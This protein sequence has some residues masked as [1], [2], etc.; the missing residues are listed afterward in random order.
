MLTPQERRIASVAALESAAIERYAEGDLA[1]S[2]SWMLPRAVEALGATAGVIHVWPTGTPARLHQSGLPP[3]AAKAFETLRPTL[4]AVPTEAKE[5]SVLE[6]DVWPKELRA[7]LQAA[8]MG[9]VLLLPLSLPETKLTKTQSALLLIFHDEPP[10]KLLELGERVARVFR[11]LSVHSLIEVAKGASAQVEAV[12]SAAVDAVIV[13]DQTGRIEI[14]NSSTERIFGRTS[15]EMI[16]QNVSTLMPEPY[17][18]DHDSYLDNYLRTGRAKIIG[19]GREARGLR[20]DGT[21]FPIDLAV[22]EIAPFDGRR[23]F[24]G[25]VR[26][27]STRKATERQLEEARERLAH[28]ARISTMGEL[29]SG[30]AHEVNQPLTAIATY[31]NACRRILQDGRT[32]DP[33]LLEGLGQISEEARRAGEIIHRLR[34]LVRRRPTERKTAAINAVVS[35]VIRLAEV[36]TRQHDIRL[37]VQLHDPLPAVQIDAVQIQQVVLNLIRNATDAMENTEPERR[38]VRVRTFPTAQREIQIDVSDNGIGLPSDTA[39]LYNPFFTTKATGIG[40]GL[41]ISRSIVGNHGGRLWYSAN[42]GGG[43]TFHFTLPV[44]LGEPHEE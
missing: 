39:E 20:K 27:I 37:E 17:R 7:Q 10:G 34:N 5:L 18:S 31:A 1:T 40:L 38:I 9:R 33:D 3:D 43:T 2:L 42:P 30:I 4:T 11:T 16:G 14:V 25:I 26:D 41:S 8:G 29:A 24:L 36:D 13:I 28:V 32:D 19:I 23:R 12:L 6:V 44:A 35:D 21:D 22:G 15:A